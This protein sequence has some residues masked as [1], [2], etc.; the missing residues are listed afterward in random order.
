MTAPASGPGGFASGGFGVR[1]FLLMA[2]GY[3]MS[4]GLRA[5]NATIAPELSRRM[6]G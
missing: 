4:Y 1:I 6:A 5:I 3:L 2:A